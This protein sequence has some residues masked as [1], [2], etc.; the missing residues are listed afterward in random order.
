MSL[1]EA[2]RAAS[3]PLRRCA[4]RELE[5]DSKIGAEVR[6]MLAATDIT[7]VGMAAA[8]RG[9]GRNIGAPAIARH[10]RGVCSCGARR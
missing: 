8:L 10:R 3:Q 2:A 4:V 6:A 7:A 1:M 9:V 5:E